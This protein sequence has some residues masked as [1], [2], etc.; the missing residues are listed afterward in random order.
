MALQLS[1]QLYFHKEI[2]VVINS[3]EIQ[4]QE[5]EAA[6]L[7]PEN[8]RTIRCHSA[9]SLGTCLNEAVRNSNG[10]YILKIDADDLYFP[11]YV[12]DMV[13]AAV[14]QSAQVIGK[15]TVY[16]Y[17]QEDNQLYLK[18]PRASDKHTFQTAGGTL[19]FDRKVLDQVK[20]R[21]DLSAGTDL[22]F[23]TDCEQHGISVFSADPYNYVYVRRSDK[24]SHTW[25]EDAT[26]LLGP[27]PIHLGGRE[28]IWRAIA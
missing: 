24:A 12:R 19:C 13:A 16:V 7:V 6:F 15:R 27:D 18:Q 23:H 2:I 11:N 14:D 28:E 5:V 9:N 17:L 4:E 21:T 8:I 10:K 1:H 22:G 3:E 25:R 20:F 26:R